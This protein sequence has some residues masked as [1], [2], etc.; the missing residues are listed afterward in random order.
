[1]V[2]AK[3]SILSLKKCEQNLIIFEKFT[4]NLQIS[5]NQ[6]MKKVLRLI[7]YAEYQRQTVTDLKIL[8][9]LLGM[10]GD[11]NKNLRNLCE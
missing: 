11:N 4:F 5:I 3:V 1:M 2:H 10:Q 7:D 9:I 8:L 6:T